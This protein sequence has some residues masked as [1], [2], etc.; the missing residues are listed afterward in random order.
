[1]L[2]LTVLEPCLESL[3]LSVFMCWSLHYLLGLSPLLT[4]TLQM[5]AWSLID[6]IQLRE[7]QASVQLFYDVVKQRVIFKTV[8]IIYKYFHSGL[9]K[10]FENC[11]KLYESS[12][13]TR[14]AG[15]K[16]KTYLK[17]QFS[18]AEFTLIDD[19]SLGHFTVPKRFHLETR[20]TFMS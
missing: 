2:P 12:A 4:F 20:Q 7:V 10:Y 3:P 6:Y 5:S 1:M 19:K 18:T 9:P 17:L 13:I 14:R 8:T 11:I 15:D 16:S